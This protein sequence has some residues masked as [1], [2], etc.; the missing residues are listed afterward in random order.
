MIALQAAEKLLQS[1]AVAQDERRG[2]D[3]IDVFPFMLRYSRHSGPF[4]STLLGPREVVDIII[5]RTAIIPDTI[6]QSWSVLCRR[7][8]I[9]SLWVQLSS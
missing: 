4:F 8:S 6:G 1:F 2:D 7:N 9:F 3:I 5:T